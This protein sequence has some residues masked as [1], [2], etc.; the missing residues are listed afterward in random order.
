[1]EYVLFFLSLGTLIVLAKIF[2]WP[3][4]KIFKLILNVVI[5][6]ILT[7]IINSVF[8]QYVHIPFNVWTATAFGFLGVPAVV[9]SALLYL[10]I[11]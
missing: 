1:M 11:L 4:K 3:L 9:V 10:I 7:L 8:V 6:L 5:G 2:M